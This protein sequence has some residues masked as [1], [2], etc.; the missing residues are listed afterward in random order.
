MHLLRNIN[1]FIAKY[2]ESTSLKSSWK[3]YL[4]AFALIPCNNQLVQIHT[5][6]YIPYRFIA[7]IL[8][9]IGIIVYYFNIMSV[10]STQNNL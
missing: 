7:F 8:Y 3:Y 4:H 1:T 2:E 5:T 6:F 10:I 9:I